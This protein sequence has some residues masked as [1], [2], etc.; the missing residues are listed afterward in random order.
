MKRVISRLLDDKDKA[1]ATGFSREKSGVVRN[2]GI[3]R[4]LKA[5]TVCLGLFPFVSTDYTSA[6]LQFTA[7][8]LQANM[9]SNGYVM[10][11]ASGARSVDKLARSEGLRLAKKTE[12]DNLLNQE[13]GS[14][15]TVEDIKNMMLM[16]KTGG[17]IFY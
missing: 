14:G 8:E 9:K 15:G 12:S 10:D 11:F 3:V 17:L 7:E 5:I 6:K 4:V 2:A 16:D 1:P 13:G